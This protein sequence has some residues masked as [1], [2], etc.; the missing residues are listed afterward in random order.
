MD[1]V[2]QEGKGEEIAGFHTCGNVLK[3]F[4]WTVGRMDFNADA[5]SILDRDG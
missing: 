1:S 4:V 2:I 3:G 5:I